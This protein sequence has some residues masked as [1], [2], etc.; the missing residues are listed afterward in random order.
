MRPQAFNGILQ[1]KHILFDVVFSTRPSLALSRLHLPVPILYLPSHQRTSPNIWHSF[2]V[3]LVTVRTAIQT[4]HSIALAISFWESS[5]VIVHAAR[6]VTGNFT[7]LALPCLA[8]HSHR[9]CRRHHRRQVRR[10]RRRCR[11][12]YSG[13]LWQYRAGA[14]ASTA[15]ATIDAATTA[16]VDACGD[17][18]SWWC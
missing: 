17:K 6:I 16:T 7:L 11:V 3:Y 5:V 4:A 1:I 18:W 8:F 15:A 2:H 13:R 14:A 9:R 10:R 12:Q